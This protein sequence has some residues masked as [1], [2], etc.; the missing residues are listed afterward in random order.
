[1]KKYILIISI[2]LVLASVL[3][4]WFLS[5]NEINNSGPV[6]TNAISLTSDGFNP[7]H[8]I[9]KQ[10]SEVVFIN[11]TGSPFWPA[12]DNHPTHQSYPEFDPKEPI[13]VGGRWTFSF[14]KSGTWS[15]HDHLSPS[16]RGTI[17][18]EEVPFMPSSQIP[19]DAVIVRRTWDGFS[20]EVTTIKID[21]EV[22]FVNESGNFSWPASDLHPTHDIYPEFDPKEPYADGTAWKFKFKKVGDWKFHDHLQSSRRGS[23]IV[24]R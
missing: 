2:L 9:V 18:V 16:F 7:A 12:S 10:F 14:N 15:Y 23:I 22:Y 20:P 8:V 4:A 6:V 11:E 19:K 13:S 5:R 17:E 3:T 24:D 1:M 21:T